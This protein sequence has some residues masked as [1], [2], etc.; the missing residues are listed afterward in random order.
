MPDL[1]TTQMKTLASR[2]PKEYDREKYAHII[3]LSSK[4]QFTMRQLEQRMGT[5]DSDDDDAKTNSKDDTSIAKDNMMD[6]NAPLSPCTSISS[7]HSTLCSPIPPASPSL[8]VSP[9]SPISTSPSPSSSPSDGDKDTKGCVHSTEERD[10]D[11]DSDTVSLTFPDT[12]EDSSPDASPFVKRPNHDTI[13]ATTAYYYDPVA[14]TC[15]MPPSPPSTTTIPKKQRKVTFA[16][17]LITATLRRSTDS[18]DSSSTLSSI[19]DNHVQDSSFLFVTPPHSPQQPQHQS[20]THHQ[21]QQSTIENPLPLPPLIHVQKK[22]NGLRGLLTRTY[23]LNEIIYSKTMINAFRLFNAVDSSTGHAKAV[24]RVVMTSQLK[25]PIRDPQGCA[26][27]QTMLK[28]FGF[29]FYV[30]L[31]LSP[32]AKRPQ[33]DDPRCLVVSDHIVT[34]ALYYWTQHQSLPLLHHATHLLRES[35]KVYVVYDRSQFLNQPSLTHA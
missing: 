34:D 7:L 8:P 23:Q 3:N 10:S 13:Y 24:L 26:L 4:L 14:P 20:Q 16:E 33:N 27:D 6:N 2:L 22:I 25:T 18:Y 19:I 5:P 17:E 15:P 30:S 29:T 32:H 1:S 28:M 35:V 21:Q 11:S 9:V 31:K 12:P